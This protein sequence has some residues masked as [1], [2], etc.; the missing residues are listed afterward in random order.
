MKKDKKD[1][2]ISEYEVLYFSKDLD[3]PFVPKREKKR[4]ENEIKEKMMN[5]VK[6]R[7]SIVEK[8]ETSENKK[9]L[10]EKILEIDKSLKEMN[11]L[12]YDDNPVFNI[13]PI[14][15]KDWYEFEFAREV[16]FG[17]KN[18]YLNINDVDSMV[19][20]M[21]M[22]EIDLFI[23]LISEHKENKINQYKFS[24]L[25]KLVCDFNVETLDVYEEN[26]KKILVINDS[27]ELENEDF[28]F[29]RDIIGYYN[30]QDYK[31]S[32]YE[33]NDIRKEITTYNNVMMRK[34]EI[35]T[36]EK[37]INVLSVLSHIKE[38]DIYEM[39]I[40]RFLMTDETANDILE[41]AVN[42][43]VEGGGHFKFKEEIPHYKFK[44]K[45]Q[46]VEGGFVPLEELRKKIA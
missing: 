45:K 34:Y 19:K 12:L 4:K 39:T 10:I 30:I 13:R 16:I 46:K 25:M 18:E 38:K 2:R 3:V 44:P 11:N 22:N 6:V 28:V 43:I 14:K 21:S 5:L 35:P 7:N 42:K 8:I 41:W 20:I 9:I 26:S 17:K 32:F 24:R 15:V 27:I 29:F 37:R 23:Y 31:P 40:R 1:K 36:L 33:N